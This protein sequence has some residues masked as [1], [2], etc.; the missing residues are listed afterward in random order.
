MVRI[1]IGQTLRERSSNFCL[2]IIRV[3]GGRMRSE[4]E[5][6]L[7]CLFC[8]FCFFFR[9]SLT[10]LTPLRFFFLGGEQEL[11][12]NDASSPCL[13]DGSHCSTSLPPLLS[14]DPL[15]LP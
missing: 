12:L 4:Q 14:F 3:L 6:S 10:L 2:C 7:L 1:V 15:P 13:T 8:Q 9:F 11:L 5:S